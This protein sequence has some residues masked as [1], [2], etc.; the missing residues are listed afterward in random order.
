M[1]VIARYHPSMGVLSGTYTPGLPNTGDRD[2]AG[3]PRWGRSIHIVGHPHP[4]FVGTEV[5]H[6]RCGKVT[7]ALQVVGPAIWVDRLGPETETGAYGGF[8]F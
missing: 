7:S 2:S 8:R 6:G 1:W 3:R 4:R 5:T